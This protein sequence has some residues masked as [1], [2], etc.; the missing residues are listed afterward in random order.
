LKHITVFCGASDGLRPEYREAAKELGRRIADHGMA[1]VYGGASTGL[2][3]ELANAALR[4]GGTVIG[5]IPEGLV[6]HEVAHPAL[7]ELHVV[8][9]MHERKERMASLGDAYVALPGGLG[10]VEEF[11]EMAT[12]AQLGFHAKP[13]ALVNTGG[14]F[15]LLLGFLKHAVAEGFVLQRFLDNIFIA[16]DAS[17]LLDGLRDHRAQPSLFE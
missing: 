11:V 14:Y 5:V 9:S 4:H 15:D 12:W 10:T 6:P 16:D 13:C 1:L 8:R 3:G 2:M 7:T 17:N